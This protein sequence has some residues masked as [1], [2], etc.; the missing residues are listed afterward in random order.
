MPWRLNNIGNTLLQNQDP[1]DSCYY[2][3]VRKG[4]ESHQN[5]IRNYIIREEKT[6]CVIRNYSVMLNELDRNYFT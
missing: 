2:A 1:V 5:R 4:G 6:C 3:S